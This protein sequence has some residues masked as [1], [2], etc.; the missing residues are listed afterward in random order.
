MHRKTPSASW[1]TH[2]MI[3]SMC[4]IM[5][6]QSGKLSLANALDTKVFAPPS[7]T[8][9]P[10]QIRKSPCQVQKSSVGQLLDL[11]KLRLR[12]GGAV[13]EDVIMDVESRLEGHTAWS[14]CF[15]SH[16]H[17]PSHSR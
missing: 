14:A 1:A 6:D 7:F 8:R 4:R 3:C 10:F 5:L 12:G 13:E 9:Y 15:S 11:F 2:L 16:P 17:A